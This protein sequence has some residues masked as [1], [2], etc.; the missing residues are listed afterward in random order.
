MRIPL[1]PLILLAHIVSCRHLELE[2]EEIL[3]T[4]LGLLRDTL[5]FTL[6]LETR[7]PLSTRI[8]ES[9]RTKQSRIVK[10]AAKELL[11]PAVLKGMAK[12]A[13]S[14]SAQ[15]V[16]AKNANIVANFAQQVAPMMNSFAVNMSE[17]LELTTCTLQMSYM[18]LIPLALV[19]I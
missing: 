12:A 2:E 5:N 6:F 18:A 8:K 3:N 4:M 9:L 1:V 10:A 14:E 11:P 16:V 17:P 13:K 19:L 15:R 7:R